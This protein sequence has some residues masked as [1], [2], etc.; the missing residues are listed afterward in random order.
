[1]D[2]NGVLLAFVVMATTCIAHGLMIAALRI[3]PASVLQPFSYAALPWAIVLSFV[4]FTS[5]STRSR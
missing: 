2:L 1:M 5:S 3:A 4:I